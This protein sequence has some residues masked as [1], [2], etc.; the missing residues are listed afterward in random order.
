M[1]SGSVRRDAEGEGKRVWEVNL[2]RGMLGR[3]KEWMSEKGCWGGVFEKGS[4]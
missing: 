4:V 2:C 3:E 1:G